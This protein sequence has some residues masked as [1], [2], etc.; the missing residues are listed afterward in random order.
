[1]VRTDKSLF[2]VL[3]IIA[4]VKLF[5]V[6]S[7][8]MLVSADAVHDDALYINLASNILNGD[9][10]GDYNVLTLIRGVFY[11]LFIAFN[12]IIGMPLLITQQL[13][14]IFAGLVFIYVLSDYIKNT[15]VLAAVFA[16]Y[17]FLPIQTHTEFMGVMRENIYA[18]E[19][20]FLFA[21]LFGLMK[22]RN[23]KW[24]VFTGLSMCMFWFTREEGL[25]V[26][27]SMIAAYLVIF[28]KVKSNGKYALVKTLPV[29][30]LPVVIVFLF[31]S[32]IAFTNNAY[33]GAY[34]VNELSHKSFLKAYGAVT[35]VKPKIW[36]PQVPVQFSTMD[37]IAS[38]SPGF[39][40]IEAIIEKHWP[41]SK[42][43]LGGG[44]FLWTLRDAVAYEGFY[45]SA[46]LALKFYEQ[47]GD[48]I[49]GLCS[50]KVL[51]CEPLRATLMPALQKEYLAGLPAT[52]IDLAV[53]ALNSFSQIPGEPCSVGELKGLL[54]FQS[55]TGNRS[56]PSE[57]QTRLTYS[58]SGWA[59]KKGDPPLQIRL[60]PR[61]ASECPYQ[62][63]KS[64]GADVVAYQKEPSAAWSRFRLETHSNTSCSIGF[65]DNSSELVAAIPLYTNPPGIRTYDKKVAI[66]IDNV[67]TAVN[68]NVTTAANEKTDVPS[69]QKPFNYSVSGW[70]YKKGTP[71]LEV[72]LIPRTAD[73]TLP[74][75]DCTYHHIERAPSADVVAYFKEPSAIW[76]RFS[77]E[78]AAD[79]LCAI[80]F[81]DNKTMLA[82]EVPLNEIPDGIRIYDNNVNL[83]IDNV[84]PFSGYEKSAATF[85][86]IPMF[87]N[88]TLNNIARKYNI[89]FPY[90]FLTALL[91]YLL[92]L[93]IFR[94]YTELFYFNTILLIG[95][96]I[97][98]ALLS[99]IDATSFP[100]FNFR[101]VAPVTALVC[102][103]IPLSL[104]D[105][106]IKIRHRHSASE[107][108]TT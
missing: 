29:L 74:P 49:N 90:L 23:Y 105:T 82:A 91:C 86:H 94:R 44:M 64:E 61:T 20:V 2:Y 41:R 96:V 18:S 93:L 36:Q 106:L 4:G 107:I 72:R 39:S 103:F 12:Y 34:I 98:L 46:P 84:T 104:I 78:T 5:L 38:H 15:T 50:R 40:R 71:P 95:I 24:A 37:E 85:K 21:S 9:W 26:V 70:A 65:Y 73:K 80:A 47:L 8:A 51:D 79:S 67:T 83:I 58:V 97:R 56:Y 101:Y 60:I 7:M 76:S 10:L 75:K 6:S 66:Y 16:F 45:T 14:F 28:I 3:L 52:F 31:Y 87:K 48:E 27:P 17:V 55:I 99:I 88:R 102:L 35:R 53:H 63:S 59:Y 68:D 62:V 32:L 25:W 11:P 42:G 81:Y 22:Y 92:N 19:V 108:E 69:K 89:F 30:G 33:Y 77:L 57:E 54:F 1:M 13:F 100:A 43:E